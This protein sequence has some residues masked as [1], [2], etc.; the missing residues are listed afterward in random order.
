[1]AL[2]LEIKIATISQDEMIEKVLKN[3]GKFLDTFR[4]KDVYYKFEKGLL[5]LRKQNGEYQ[6]VKYNR[7]ESKGE[8][9]SDY[10]LLFLT[11][12]NVEDYLMDLFEVE[13]IV[14]KK[15]SLYIYKNTRIHLDVVK[16]LGNFL[17]LET[18]VQKITK[19]EAITEF[20][21]VVRYLE[22]DENKQIKKSYRDLLIKK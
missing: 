3:G 20:N 22:L 19:Q 21:N 5:K 14:E 13:I 9:W 17:E 10:S 16:N 7:N 1:M 8:R 15:R 12:D 2:N 18:V 4:Q 11:G 6:L